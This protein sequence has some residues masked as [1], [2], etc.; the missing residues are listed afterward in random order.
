L[1]IEKKNLL[2]GAPFTHGLRFPTTSF[3]WTHKSL[4]ATFTIKAPNSPRSAHWC[5]T[6]H[7]FIGAA[8]S[9]LNIWT[10]KSVHFNRDSTTDLIQGFDKIK[11]TAHIFYDTR[12]LDIPEGLPKWD[13][14]ENKSNRLDSA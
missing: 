13:E 8:N 1:L 6:C 4:E 3:S 10:L 7:T 12:V 9:T 2:Q 5:Q 11:P 14:H